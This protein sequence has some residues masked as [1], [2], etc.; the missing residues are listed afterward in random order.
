MTR[1]LA[2]SSA[3]RVLGDWGTTRLRL[4]L[5][6]DRQVLEQREGPGIGA[7]VRSPA[8]TLVESIGN[9]RDGGLSRVVLAGMA[10][11]RNGLLEVPYLQALAD[12]PAW[13]RAARSIV[14]N[15][16]S[17]TVAAGLRCDR[18]ETADVMRG[19]ENQIYGALEMK[20]ALGEASHLLILPGTHSK[21]VEIEDGVI[22]RF[23]TA[24]TGEL[25]ALLR[26]HSILLRTGGAAEHSQSESDEGFAAGIQRASE[27][28]IGLVNNAFE[29]RTAQLLRDRSR[30]WAS[31]FLSGL[32]I[33]E[34]I[35]GLSSRYSVAHG[36]TLIGDPQLSALYSSTF[37]QRGI[38]TDI[39]DGA[40]C[41][42]R[43]LRFLDTFNEGQTP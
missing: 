42:L 43:G 41:A 16:L 18:D 35:G 31:G 5:V 12:R 1:R 15:D 10:G 14:V 3:L 21:W 32:V 24:L 29:A 38:R 11:S 40:S 4:L 7:L 26:D 34:E 17:V 22:V 9:W 13:S 20:P 8:D 37:A 30:S 19:E 25:Y 2:P 27:S 33:G 6:D 39:L 23:H 28:G 36:V